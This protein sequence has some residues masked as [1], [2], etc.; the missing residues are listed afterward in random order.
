MTIV[1]NLPCLGGRPLGTNFANSGAEEGEEE[2]E[3]RKRQ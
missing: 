3:V 1:H 2:E